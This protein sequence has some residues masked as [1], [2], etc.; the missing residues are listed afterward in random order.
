MNPYAERVKEYRVVIFLEREVH[1]GGLRYLAEI[2]SCLQRNG[3]PTFPSAI[4]SLA[5]S[6]LSDLQSLGF[7]TSEK[8]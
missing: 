8:Y 3:I 7:Y 1:T 2:F 6:L 5:D 4:E